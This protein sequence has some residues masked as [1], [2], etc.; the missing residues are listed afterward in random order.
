MEGVFEAR[1]A[2][3]SDPVRYYHGVTLLRDI[4]GLK[5][6]DQ[7]LSATYHIHNKDLMF[8]AADEDDGFPVVVGKC[9]YKGR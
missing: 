3:G 5:K 6:G 4:A 1:G 8:Y 2:H 7:L 9:A